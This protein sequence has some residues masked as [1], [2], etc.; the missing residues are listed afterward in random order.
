MYSLRNIRKHSKV[1]KYAINESNDKGVR[2][3]NKIESEEDERDDKNE[4]DEKDED[5]EEDDDE[6]E[7]VKGSNEI[8]CF[9]KECD[10]EIKD[11]KMIEHN[12]NHVK[13]LN[14]IEK[15]EMKD[16][17]ISMDNFEENFDVCEFKNKLKEKWAKKN[18]VINEMNKKKLAYHP[19]LKCSDNSNKWI[20][21]YSISPLSLHYIE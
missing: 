7:E 17:Y 14:A 5:N 1:C 19:E 18:S 12:S 6:E 10:C 13:C 2:E 21:P 11:D 15:T 9:F 4:C 20:W 16:K 3:E 8:R